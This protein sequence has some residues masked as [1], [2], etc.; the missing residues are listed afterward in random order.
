MLKTAVITGSGDVNILKIQKFL[1][2]NENP[3]GDTTLKN[4]EMAEMRNFRI[5]QDNHLQI[6]P[7]AQ[8][9][10]S[11]AQALS[12]LLG[13]SYDEAENTHLYGVWRGYVGTGEH[14]LV[15]FG[16]YI[17]DV[18]LDSGECTQKGT[19]ARS[20]AAFFGFDEKV[21]FIN[22]AEYKSWDG[23]AET[24][25][26]DVEG[27]V[28]LVQISTAPEGAGTL[29]EGVNRLTGKKRVQFSPD[30]ESTVFQ[31][32]EKNIDEIISVVLNGVTEQ[33]H[34]ENLADGTVTISTAPESG[35][36]TLEIT[37][38]KGTGARGEV[39]GMRFCELFNGSSDT[40]VF[41]YGDG[42]NRAIYSGIPYDT[43][44]ASAEYFP[45]LYEIA[46]GE[47]NTPLT[48]L[49]RHYSRL[50]AFKPNSAWVIQYGSITLEDGGITAAFYVQP[51]NRQ[52]GNEA[53]GQVRLL[54]NNPL[55]LDVGSIYQWKP[56]SSS[57]Y[58][59]NSENNAKRIS[60]RIS[61]TL[62]EFKLAEVKT[63]NIKCDHEYWFMYGRKAVIL[64][65]SNDTWYIY[66]NLPFDRLLEAENE[67]YGFCDDGDI[68]HFSRQY[69]NDN[70]AEIS[71]Y[72]A[73]GAMD[74]D[75]DWLLKYSPMIFV[76]M[77]PET[78]ARIYVTVETNKRSDYPEKPVAYNIATFE[79]VN[80]NHFSFST[81]RKP[82]VKRVKLKVKKATFYRLIFKSN[83]ASATATIIETDIKLRYAGAVK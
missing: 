30:G 69:R 27:Y 75:R 15:S 23:G 74:F 20:E 82:Q 8:S 56:L 36:N 12:E 34:T 41:L 33:T 61:D 58:I 32:P 24:M 60:D 63:Y 37:Y 1:G 21:Y 11:L 35:T 16:G 57:G 6:R 73:T 9:I 52:F 13:E 62:R 2:L 68:V 25:F 42:S 45:D 5:T 3:D 38:R 78:G 70:G 67:K 7:G 80:F 31:L 71:C 19:A 28:P 77:Q 48:A 44:R 43:G 17:W 46:V 81:N 79:H 64:N 14:T 53:P 65:Y 26:S 50:M 66:E 54:E 29:L 76:A 47:S 72:A 55:T 49:V 18:N 39:T 4:G 10:S 83:S 59:S 22:S 51:V 40:R